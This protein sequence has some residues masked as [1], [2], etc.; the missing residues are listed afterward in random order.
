MLFT[1]SWQN[2]G[3]LM[4]SKAALSSFALELMKKMEIRYRPPAM[5]IDLNMLQHQGVNVNDLSPHVPTPDELDPTMVE[6]SNPTIPPP[7]ER[8]AVAA[9]FGAVDH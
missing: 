6:N 9:M 1:E 3:A 5:P 4:G 7:L 2:I 8:T